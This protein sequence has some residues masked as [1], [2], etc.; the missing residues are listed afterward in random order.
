MRK[1]TRVD[2]RKT[3][4]TIDRLN[5]KTN[6]WKIPEISV[7]HHHLP[8]DN[9]IIGVEILM[10]EEA[11]NKYSTVKKYDENEVWTLYATSE[12]AFADELASQM[13]TC[14]KSKKTHLEKVIKNFSFTS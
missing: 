5:R 13:L 4:E 3:I 10:F 2:D 12:S 1:L 9:R 8:S 14:I 11:K 6:D 7:V